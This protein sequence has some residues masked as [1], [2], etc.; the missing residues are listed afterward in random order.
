MPS[1]TDYGHSIFTDLLVAVLESSDAGAAF[2]DEKGKNLSA[3]KSQG[4]SSCIDF[5]T[6]DRCSMAID[7]KQR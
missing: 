5:K 2:C 7:V 3:A 4:I 6:L 1:F